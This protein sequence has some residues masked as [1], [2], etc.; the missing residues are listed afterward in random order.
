MNR[1]EARIARIEKEAFG[2]EDQEPVYFV[3][4]DELSGPR[5]IA[6]RDDHTRRGRDVSLMP[7]S[8]APHQITWVALT[9]DDL[10]DDELQACHDNL[11][12]LIANHPEA[13]R[14]SDDA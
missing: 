9:L 13:F 1:L 4:D 11:S 8:W 2:T 7:S 6:L 5:A 14:T 12:R 3:P 10:T